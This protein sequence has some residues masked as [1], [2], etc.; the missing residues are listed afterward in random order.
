MTRK[1]ALITG[2]ASGIGQALAVAY[3]HQG[4]TV[5]GGYYPADPHDPQ[6]TCNL[7]QEAGGECLMWALDVTDSRSVDEL[8]EQAVKA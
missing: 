1:V 2:A 5:V 6:H 7:V 4:V 8:A 3:A